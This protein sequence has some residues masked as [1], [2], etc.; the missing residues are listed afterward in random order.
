MESPTTVRGTPA[1][2]CARSAADPVNSFA[3][4]GE[5]RLQRRHGFGQFVPVQG[6]PGLQAQGVA[7]AE[8]RG[9]SPGGQQ[10]I[11]DRDE[12]GERGIDLEA[13]LAGVPGAGDQGA[14]S[15]DG[16]PPHVVCGHG[17]VQVRRDGEEDG[18]R[19]RAL[20]GEDA[21]G[22]AL[23]DEFR[24]GGQGRAQ[25]V[26]VG[27]EIPRVHDHLEFVRPRAAHQ[28]VVH[29]PA[30]DVG[31]GGILELPDGE[32]GNRVGGEAVQM[33]QG[34]GSADHESAHVGDVRET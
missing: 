32:L 30:T 23:V 17:C 25:E 27:R 18:G 33:R 3:D 14:N 12:F 15:S 28:D 7:G 31:E 34:A 24:P 9:R 22:Q 1:A 19:V 11:P 6:I 29:Q 20:Q 2:F 10:A 13:V 5:T 26:A 4:P 16:G 21:V 8:P